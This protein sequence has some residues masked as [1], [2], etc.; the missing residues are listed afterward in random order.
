MA[1][2]GGGKMLCFAG[3]IIGYEGEGEEP[4]YPGVQAPAEL[5]I[6]PLSRNAIGKD[7]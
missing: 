3:A 7:S 2:L 5:G 4:L 6:L 1:I